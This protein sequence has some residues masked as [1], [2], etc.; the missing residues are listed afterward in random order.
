V[1]SGRS[2]TLVRVP[3]SDKTTNVVEGR[4]LDA[5]AFV[6]RSLAAKAQSVAE[7]EAK[8]VARGVDA[9]EATGVVADAVRLGFLDDAELAGQLARGFRARGYGRRRAARTLARR[10][11]PTALATGALEDAYGT[12]VDGELELA[13]RALGSRAVDGDAARRRAVGFLVRRG[14]SVGIAWRVV[15]CARPP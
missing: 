8:L 11:I 5:R 10:G 3:S 4:R 9:D 13:Q 2:I 15:R 14:F 6:V 1:S 12:G 7:I